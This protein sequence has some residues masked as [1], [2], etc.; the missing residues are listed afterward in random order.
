[1]VDIYTEGYAGVTTRTLAEREREH[2]RAR[3]TGDLKRVYRKWRQ[4]PEATIEPVFYG[5]EEEVIAW[6]KD[7]RPTACIAWNIAPGG[8]KPGRECWYSDK[9]LDVE[10]Y[11]PKTWEEVIIGPG[12][13]INDFVKDKVPELKQKSACDR[14]A[15]L[16]YGYQP[17]FA[18]WE[19]RDSQLRNE[20]EIRLSTNWS[21][22]YLYSKQL[23]EYKYIL[24]K[25]Q[26]PF[27]KSIGITTTRNALNRLH[28]GR[29]KSLG[30]DKW[31]MISKTKY[32]SET[33]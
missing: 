12:Y 22:L 4:S 24:K 18:N 16:M 8:G 14:T 26:N 32:E 19:F 17:S 10:L 25:D 5:T 11:N 31:I 27:L 6:E 2:I 23:N 28:L 20:I 33:K 13:W 15:F 9:W 1:M 21:E 3:D 30:E 7:V 29:L